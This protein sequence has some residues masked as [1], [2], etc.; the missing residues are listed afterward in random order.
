VA[1]GDSGGKALKSLERLH[2]DPHPIDLG[3]EQGPADGA[4]DPTM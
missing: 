3:E 1:V 2:A 4:A